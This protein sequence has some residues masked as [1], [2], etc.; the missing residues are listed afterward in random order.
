MLKILKIVDF[1]GLKRFLTHPCT[2]IILIQSFLFLYICDD[3]RIASTGVI[4]CL[5]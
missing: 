2:N 3:F 5:Q 1:I 4:A